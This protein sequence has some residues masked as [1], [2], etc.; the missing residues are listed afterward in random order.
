MD[1]KGE[2]YIVL[3]ELAHTSGPP[4]KHAKRAMRASQMVT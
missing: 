4:C 2:I 3:I 1:L